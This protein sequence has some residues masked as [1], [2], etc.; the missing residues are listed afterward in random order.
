[1]FKD[2]KVKE[3]V[4]NPILDCLAIF[5]KMSGRP[6][7]KE[8]LISG[9]PI[10]EGHSSP[11]LF[12]KFSSKSLFS[13]AAA[14]AGFKTRVLKTKIEDINPLVLPCIVLLNGKNPK[15][16]LRACILLGF[17]DEMANARVVL[18]EAEDVENSVTIEEL[19]KYYFGFSILLKK[20]L[21]FDDKQL[22]VGD[23][24]ENHW[25][26]GTMKI[27]RDT[28]RDVI[29]ASLL[30]NIFVLATPLF[31]MNVYDRVIPNDAKDT[32]WI[33]SIGVLIVY[34]IDVV[35]KFLRTY[36]LETAGKKTDIIA[37]SL[38]FERVLDLKMSSM[39]SSVGSMANILKE[40]ESIRSFITSSTI[41]LLIDLPFI[42]LF[43]IT[44]YYI[45]G[46]LVV[47]PVVIIIFIVFYTL[48][49]K[50]KLQN[51][52][53]QSYE[54]SSMKNGVLIESLS[55]IETLKSLGATGYSQWKW[56]EATSQIADKSISSKTISA[57][58]TTVTSFLLQLNTVAI[59]IVGTYLIG[60]KMISMGAL[61]AVVIIS[62]RAI[63]PMG[64]VASLLSTFHHTKV[65]YKALDD[66]MNMPVEHPQGKKFVAR[67]EYRGNIEFKNVGF[68]YPNSDKS[69]LNNLNFRIN[70]GEHIAIIGKIGSGKSTIHKL[71]LSLYVPNEGAI[72]V[73]NIDTKQLDPTELR[74][75]IAYVSQDVLLFNGTVKENIVYRLPHID[76][77]KIIEAATVSGVMDFINKHPKGFDMPV[78]ER[79]AFLS[80]GQ[81]QSIAIARA[82]LQDYPI[83]LLD[84]PTSAMDSSTEAKF[85]KSIKEYLKGKTMILVTHK[86]SLLSLADRVIVM[87]DGQIVLDGKKDYVVEKL[88]TK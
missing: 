43:L 88:R 47:V 86:T 80:G 23:V 65:S 19:K 6:Y 70:E 41:S 44:I 40:F 26:W 21:R 24:K 76:D 51:S 87:E 46:V 35:L 18:P 16:E 29:I 33:L 37:S 27:V 5:C 61:I 69:T 38:I 53:K 4:E 32:L 84:E 77:E 1:M 3:Y 12:S 72:L 11:V 83:V 54:A 30:I 50:E 55:S 31:T 59:I 85:I 17:D 42:I 64:Q 34:G 56:E 74:K 73:D 36:F 82:I 45:G 10:E 58:I 14:K 28:Y 25:L 39:P 22:T 66:I 49:A 20:E 9:L 78:G 60:E 57:S 2:I 81:R 71:L 75:N 52:I 7:S 63:A 67:P 48:Y 15:D 79:G 62:S 68:T 8:S 13:R